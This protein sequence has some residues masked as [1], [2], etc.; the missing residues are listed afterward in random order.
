MAQIAQQDETVKQ[1]KRMEALINSMTPAERRDPDILNGSRKRRVCQGSGTDL[2]DLNRLLK[3]HKQMAKMMKKLK[4]GKGMANM[5]RGISGQ[6]P[7]GL[8]GGLPG[9]LGGG[10][11]L[12]GKLR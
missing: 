5:M 7:A 2:Q 12:P 11:K 9:G 10:M 4:G 1:F 6:L 8:G 3:Q